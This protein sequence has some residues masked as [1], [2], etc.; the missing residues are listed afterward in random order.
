MNKASHNF[1]VNT[2][3]VLSSKLKSSRY[4]YPF[5]AN[6]GIIASKTDELKLQQMSKSGRN[7]VSKDYKS[8]GRREHSSSEL[9]MYRGYDRIDK[10]YFTSGTIT[11][12]IN[13][14]PHNH[15]MM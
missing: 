8:T 10:N 3:R 12:T 11:S 2:Q 15:E 5:T 7:S 6:N 13:L 9:K 14:H 1:N 4:Q